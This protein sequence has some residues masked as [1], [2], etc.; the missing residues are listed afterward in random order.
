MFS[1]SMSDATALGELGHR[2]AKCRLNRNM[3]Q[4]ALAAEAGVSTPTI[5]RIEYGRST[6]T[7][8]LVRVLRALGLLEN[9]EALVPAPAASP[10]QQAKLRGKERRRA[11]SPS[12]DQPGQPWTWSDEE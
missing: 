11:S 5:Q 9:L 12:D 1:G 10:L 6:Q 3:T 2:I 7:A 4:D 8:N